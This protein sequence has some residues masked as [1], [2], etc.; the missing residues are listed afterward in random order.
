MP[1]SNLPGSNL[2]VTDENLKN[3]KIHVSD[4]VMNIQEVNDLNDL[5]AVFDHNGISIQQFDFVAVLQI[6]IADFEARD[7]QQVLQ[8]QPNGAV[9][10]N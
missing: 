8:R 4:F 5:V 3:S 6:A 10:D 2:P 1:G 7:F 9:T